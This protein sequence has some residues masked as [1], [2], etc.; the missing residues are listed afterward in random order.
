LSAKR[1]KVAMLLPLAATPDQ[2]WEALDR[3]VRNQ[4]RKA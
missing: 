2:Q 3:K 4:V 1:H